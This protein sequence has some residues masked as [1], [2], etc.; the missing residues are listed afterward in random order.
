MSKLHP[1]LPKARILADAIKAEFPLLSPDLDAWYEDGECGGWSWTEHGNPGDLHLNVDAGVV[2]LD[3]LD[4]CDWK[5]TLHVSLVFDNMSKTPKK[6]IITVRLGD[7]GRVTD[8][9]AWATLGQIQGLGTKLVN[10]ALL[11]TS[12][13]QAIRAA[14]AKVE[15]P[16]M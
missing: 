3:P 16:L 12:I 9:F 11:G 5:L 4:R 8:P 1:F 2:S 14:C 6:A 13:E 7:V 15:L 10:L